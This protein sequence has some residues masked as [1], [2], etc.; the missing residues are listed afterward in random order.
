MNRLILALVAFIFLCS[1]F[2]SLADNFSDGVNAA[3][4]IDNGE[5]ARIFRVSAEKGDRNSQHILGVMLY[6]GLGDRQN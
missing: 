5:A 1:P 2:F 6:K 4:N 3:I